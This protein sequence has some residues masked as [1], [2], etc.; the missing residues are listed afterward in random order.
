[1]VNRHLRSGNGLRIQPPAAS[2]KKKQS[3]IHSDHRMVVCDF[4]LP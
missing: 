1:M 4:L 2:Q 3:A